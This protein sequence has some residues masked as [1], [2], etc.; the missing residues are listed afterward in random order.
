MINFLKYKNA[1]ILFSFILIGT[2]AVAYF[3][4]GGFKYAIDFSGGAEINI[5]FEKS[6]DIGVLRTAISSQGWQDSVIQSVGKDGKNF[7][8][9]LGGVTVEGLEEKFRNAV[10][11]ATPGNTMTVTHIDWIGAEVGKDMKKNAIIAILLSLLAI[12]IYVAIRSRYAYGIGAVVALCH[13]MLAVLV[14]ILLFKE[15]MSLSVLAAILAILGY[16]INDTIVIF[17]RI[18]ENVKKMKDHSLNDIVTTSINQTLRRTLLTSFSTLLSVT[19]FYFLGGEALRGF[20]FVMMAGII[21]GTYSSIYIASPV[22]IY[23]ENRT[24][25]K[26]EVY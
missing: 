24:A 9:K 11:A 6:I 8:V 17:S 4:Q 18:R 16:S 10:D 25:S 14:I 13:D 2:G 22:M 1:C 26:K 5:S 19:A 12:L 23:L 20:S 21:F 7:I 3:V 15:P